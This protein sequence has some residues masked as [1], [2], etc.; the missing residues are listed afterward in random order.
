MKNKFGHGMI[1]EMDEDEKDRH[2]PSQTPVAP[3]NSSALSQS[4]LSLRNQGST[5][6]KK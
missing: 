5:V 3:Y 6:V 4:S 1:V 2:A